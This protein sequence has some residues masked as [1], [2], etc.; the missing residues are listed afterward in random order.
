MLPRA[1][2]LD[3]TLLRSSKRLLISPSS[4]L[5]SSG[6]DQPDHADEDGQ[7]FYPYDESDSD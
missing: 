6:E 2:P 1:F 4:T 7:D 3:V 5:I